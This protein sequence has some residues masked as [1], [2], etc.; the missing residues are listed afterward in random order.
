MPTIITHPAVALATVPLLKGIQKKPLAVVFG[1]LL[2]ILPDIDVVA[3]KAGIP[4][5]HMFGHRGFSHSILFAFLVSLLVAFAVKQ[6]KLSKNLLVWLYLFICAVSHGLLD[7]ITN[8]GL[9]VGFFIPFSSE[10]YF[11]EYRPIKVSTLSFDRFINGKG[12]AVLQN[13]FL[14]IWI[15]AFLLLLALYFLKKRSAPSQNHDRRLDP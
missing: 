6:S 2:S 9:G 7:A 3:F 4:Y 10:R 13:E 8:G 12:P 14:Y 1:M 15:P 11:F 5:G